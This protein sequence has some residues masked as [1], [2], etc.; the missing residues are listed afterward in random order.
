M[1]ELVSN[2]LRN[3]AVE[4][5]PFD[6]M[7]YY[8][9]EL[10]RTLTFACKRYKNQKEN[11]L[12]ITPDNVEKLTSGIQKELDIL[13]HMSDETVDFCKDTSSIRDDKKAKQFEA[14]SA[15]ALKNEECLETSKVFDMPCRNDTFE[16]TRLGEDSNEYKRL[17]Y[18]R[19]LV[20]T[21]PEFKT[22]NE[23]FLYDLYDILDLEEESGD[24]AKC[25]KRMLID[26]YSLT[27]DDIGYIISLKKRG[28]SLLAESA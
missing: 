11:G 19:K 22:A 21:V 17:L 24:K 25:R 8:S 23:D 13:K 2:E 28:K 27:E 4:D 26:K 10:V 18:L 12:Q 14:I 7:L 1:S 3:N 5:N 20:M 6:N 16:K 15:T 9:L